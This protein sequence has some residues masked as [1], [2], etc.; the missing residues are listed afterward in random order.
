MSESTLR[1][2]L[3]HAMAN[4]GEPVMKRKWGTGRVPKVLANVLQAKK[5]HLNRD[6]T[7]IAGQQKTVIPALLSI[8]IMT[9]QRLCPKDLNLP[10]RK[11][12]ARSLLTQ[13]VKD[14]RLAFTHQYLNSPGGGAEKGNVL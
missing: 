8:S 6:P 10:Y 4:P 14:K 5:S 3:A 2:V 9:I 12:A 1:R 7:L 11:M 13:A